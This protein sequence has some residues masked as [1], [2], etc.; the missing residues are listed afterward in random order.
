MSRKWIKIIF[1]ITFILLV[2]S[3][4]LVVRLQ[5]YSVKNK[6]LDR[7]LMT[8]QIAEATLSKESITKLDANL[9]DLNKPEYKYIKN[10]LMDIVRLDP[11]ISFAYLYVQRNGNIYFLVDSEPVSSDDYSPPGQ[12]YQE[13]SVEDKQPFLDAKPLVTKPA[14]DR[15][16]EWVSVLVPVFD[17][18]NEEVIAVFALDYPAADWYHQELRETARVALYFLFLLLLL[19]SFYHII[20]KNRSIRENE[21]KFR[22]FL[23]SSQDAVIVINKK[24]KVILWNKAAHKTFGYIGSEIIGKELSNYLNFKDSAKAKV[25]FL[26]SIYLNKYKTIDSLVELSVNNKEG[27][28]IIVELSF[29]RVLINSDLH[30]IFII[31]DITKRKKTD[32]LIKK[33][34]EEKNII[35]DESERINKLM[36][37]RELEMIKLKKKILELSNKLNNL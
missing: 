5:W 16:G 18:S 28:Q 22:A 7:V 29:S 19:I 3:G 35:I 8:A 25:N 36:I 33:S 34:V 24:K 31:R 23:D 27:K 4:F 1:I 21:A 15:W 14:K 20:L 10:S 9:S 32:E 17:Q 37:G 6:Q 2:L 12:E 13:A 30:V 11:E 26:E